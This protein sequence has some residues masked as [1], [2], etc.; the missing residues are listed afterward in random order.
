MK[1]I[2]KKSKKERKKY[3]DQ[4]RNTWGELNPITRVEPKNKSKK[5]KEKEIEKSKRNEYLRGGRVSA[6]VV[7]WSGFCYKI[8][9][10]ETT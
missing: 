3:Y 1:S 6:Q 9:I 2:D 7:R 8:K 4:F 5:K 10:L